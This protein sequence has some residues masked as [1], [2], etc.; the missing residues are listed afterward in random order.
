MSR[1]DVDSVEIFKPASFAS[2]Q[3]AGTNLRQSRGE[4]ER[5][6]KLLTGM[7][8]VDAENPKLT[9]RALVERRPS[10]RGM[11]MF[12]IAECNSSNATANSSGRAE[13]KRQRP[14]KD[15]RRPILPE[16]PLEDKK[17]TVLGGAHSSNKLLPPTL[18][19]ID[20]PP[21]FCFALHTSP[22]SNAKTPV[23]CTR[24]ELT[25]F[26]SVLIIRR[27]NH[28][29]QVQ[30]NRT[31]GFVDRLAEAGPSLC[32][33]DIEPRSLG[34]PARSDC[35]AKTGFFFRL[36]KEKRSLAFF[37]PIGFYLHRWI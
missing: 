19:H 7:N 18:D 11:Q 10:L 4:R 33:E 32:F 37:R 34:F 17:F 25:K 12:F 22:K 30:S 5:E 2:A 1:A 21:E 36:S 9:Q 23:A 24:P 16:T 27:R 35:D 13:N 20:F 29:R 14:T 26:L 31:Q 6:R 8:I 3:Q 28:L 15:S